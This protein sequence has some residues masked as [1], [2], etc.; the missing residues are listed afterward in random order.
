VS[1][2]RSIA[3]LLAS[4]LLI[5]GDA[6]IISS[7]PRDGAKDVDPDT[8]VQIRKSLQQRCKLTLAA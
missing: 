7:T 3:L 6:K 4:L 8:A 5:G 1:A 2:G